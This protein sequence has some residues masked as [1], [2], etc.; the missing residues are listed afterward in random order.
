MNQPK[1]ILKIPLSWMYLNLETLHTFLHKSQ[2][3]RIQPMKQKKPWM[4]VDLVGQGGLFCGPIL[5]IQSF[6]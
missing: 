6:L 4:L 1:A 5:K 2:N 3:Q